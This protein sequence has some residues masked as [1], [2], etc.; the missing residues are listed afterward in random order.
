MADRGRCGSAGQS[1]LLSQPAVRVPASAGSAANPT[2]VPSNGRKIDSSTRPGPVEWWA[3][4][5]ALKRRWRKG[6]PHSRHLPS[7]GR[8]DEAARAGSDLRQSP[9]EPTPVPCNPPRARDEGNHHTGHAEIEPCGLYQMD[10]GRTVKIGLWQTRWAR[11]QSETA[12]GIGPKS[13]QREKLP[14]IK[15]RERAHCACLIEVDPR[16]LWRRRRGLF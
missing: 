8:L 16:A 2:S 7:T 15:V 3:W 4:P 5:A 12:G 6:L 10:I 11:S 1:F 14:R 9:P 13:A